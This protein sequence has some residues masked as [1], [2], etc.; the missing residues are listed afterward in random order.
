L[1]RPPIARRV[2]PT[3]ADYVATEPASWWS[4]VRSRRVREERSPRKCDCCVTRHRL[5]VGLSA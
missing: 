4:V 1:A 3:G 5:T 2:E